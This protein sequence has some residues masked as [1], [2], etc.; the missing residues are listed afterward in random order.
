MDAL[1]SLCAGLVVIMFAVAVTSCMPIA[2]R[3]LSS[4]QIVPTRLSPQQSFIFAKRLVF[5]VNGSVIS[6]VPGRG[7]LT[8]RNIA[9]IIGAHGDCDRRWV[10]MSAYEK[11]FRCR[12]E[13][14]LRTSSSC[15]SA[16]RR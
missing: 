14:P 3:W 8:P 5:Y 7:S 15:A 2:G 10:R 12:A 1:G 6:Y 9:G 11:V 13:R 16:P 4:N